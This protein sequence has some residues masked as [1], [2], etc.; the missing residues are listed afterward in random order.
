MTTAYERNGIMYRA[1]IQILPSFLENMVSTSLQ[2]S[3]LLKRIFY[4]T[5]LFKDREEHGKNSEFHEYELS[6][7]ISVR[8]WNVS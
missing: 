1:L 7:A 6:G 5:K 4:S 8:V 3:F 2:L